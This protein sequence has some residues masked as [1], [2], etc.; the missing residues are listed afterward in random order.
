MQK[1]KSHE[2]LQPGYSTHMGLRALCRYTCKDYKASTVF[3]PKFGDCY[4]QDYIPT[5]DDRICL[6]FT[7]CEV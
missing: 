7:D 2:F 5:S 6:A 3:H 1:L 4:K